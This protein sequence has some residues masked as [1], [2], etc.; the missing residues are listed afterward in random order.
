MTKNLLI[1]SLL[2]ITNMIANAKQKA[3]KEYFGNTLNIGAGV[4]YYGYINTPLP[5]FIVNY[6]IDVVRNFTLAPFIGLYSFRNNSYGFN[7][8]P[9]GYTYRETVMPIGIK[10]TYYFDELLHANAKWD[11]YAAAS[12]AFLVRRISWDADY[13]GSHDVY[14]NRPDLSMDAHLGAEYHFSKEA[15]LFLDVS[16]GVS[17]IGLAIH[18]NK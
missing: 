10:G 15:G 3:V 2:L 14:K 4:G 11:F 5:V 8:N 18:F 16:T 17:T 13:Y 12:S 6:E 1:I 7:T 9:K